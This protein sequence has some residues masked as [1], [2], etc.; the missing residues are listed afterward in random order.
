MDL[1]YIDINNH[2][3]KQEISTINRC[4]LYLQVVT[5]TDICN[6]K[7]S[8]FTKSAIFGRR[9]KS[10][11]SKWMW[12]NQ[13]RPLEREWDIWRLC[14]KICWQPKLNDLLDLGN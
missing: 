1:L 11:Q 7:W 5:A 13:R 8:E 4:R 14:M 9:D 12:P 10:R 2:F 3:I 6:A